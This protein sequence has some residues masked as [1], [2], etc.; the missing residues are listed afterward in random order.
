MAQEAAFENQVRDRR[1][2][3]GWSQDEL[4]RRSGLSRAGISAIE[5]GRLVPSAAAAL[6]IAA[7]LECRVEDVFQL[8][9]RLDSGPVWAWPAE[10]GKGRYWAAE[11]GGL[12]RLYP[13]EATA[14]GL[15]PHDGVCFEGSPGDKANRRSDEHVA[16]GF[17]DC[18]LQRPG[19]HFGFGLLRSGR[20]ALGRGPGPNL[21]RASLATSPAQLLGARSARPRAGAC[22]R[23]S[24][25]PG[26]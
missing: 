13:V 12:V 21:R 11:V 3:R 26:R 19:Q 1:S 2:S 9:S 18:K 20:R 8:R 10:R 22:R 6:A 16:N 14:L 25:E 17:E 23:R 5:T 15:I 24:S 7:A 4:A